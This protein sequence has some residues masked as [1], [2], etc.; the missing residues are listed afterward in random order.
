MTIDMDFGELIFLHR[1]PHAGLVRLPDVPM[2][3]RIA[4]LAEV[5]QQYREALEVRAVITVSGQRI[6]ISYPLLP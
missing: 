3:K 2:E 6:R 4:L 1:M 5:L